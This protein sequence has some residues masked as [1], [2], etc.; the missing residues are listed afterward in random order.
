MHQNE[1]GVHISVHIVAVQKILIQAKDISE[2][3]FD[4]V[5]GKPLSFQDSLTIVGSCS[6]NSINVDYEK[7]DQCTSTDSECES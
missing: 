5:T 4:E 6:S 1:F 7:K 3:T 2:I